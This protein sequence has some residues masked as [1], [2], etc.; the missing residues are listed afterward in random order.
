MVED[1]GIEFTDEIAK[2]LPTKEWILRLT[3]ASH[4]CEKG[5]DESCEATE[6]SDRHESMCKALLVNEK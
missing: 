3:R 6:N 2:R 5:C 1:E 4:T